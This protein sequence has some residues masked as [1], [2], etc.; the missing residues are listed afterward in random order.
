MDTGAPSGT[1]RPLPAQ[2]AKN[3]DTRDVLARAARQKREKHLEDYLIVDVDAHHYETQSWGEIVARI[4]DPVCKR[5]RQQLPPERAAH[6]G[7]PQQL[8]HGRRTRTSAGASPT[9]AAS[10]RRSTTAAFPATSWWCAAPSNPWASTSRFCF[11]RR[12]WGSACTP[13]STSRSTI[14]ARLQPV[15]LRAHP[16]AGRP[17]QEA[18]LHAVQRSPRHASKIVEEFGDKKGVAGS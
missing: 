11:R 4:P 13:S 1:A 17:H 8:E 12:C 10:R 16:A 9:T 18:A 7:H 6:A 14:G 15:A 5:H 3:S 2:L